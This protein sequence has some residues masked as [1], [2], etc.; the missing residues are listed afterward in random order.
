MGNNILG[1]QIIGTIDTN[2][3]SGLVRPTWEPSWESLPAVVD[4]LH[5]MPFLDKSAINVRATTQQQLSSYT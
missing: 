1:A 2:I 4:Q 3:Y 5:I